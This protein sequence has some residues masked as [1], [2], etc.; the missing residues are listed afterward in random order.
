M[1]N[2]GRHHRKVSSTKHHDP[3]EIA[4]RSFEVCK[5]KYPGFAP[6]QM[7]KRVSAVENLIMR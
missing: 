6:V 3:I 4:F 2:L 5:T 7:C 1:H